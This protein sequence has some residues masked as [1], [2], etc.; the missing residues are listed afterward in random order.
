MC[1][2]VS[3]IDWDCARETVVEAKH[4]LKVENVPLS[5]YIILKFKIAKY[6]L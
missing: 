5:N 2:V 3:R 4:S 6:S 1:Y